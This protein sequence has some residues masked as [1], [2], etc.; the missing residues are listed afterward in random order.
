LNHCAPRR[1]LVS[2]ESSLFLVFLTGAQAV[3]SKM[4]L[5]ERSYKTHNHVKRTRSW[6]RCIVGQRR[7]AEDDKQW[8]TWGEV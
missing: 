2:A 7:E 5:P 4:T 8:S 1:A 6:C 3:Q